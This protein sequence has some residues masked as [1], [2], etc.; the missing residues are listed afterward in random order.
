MKEGIEKRIL[1]WS[2]IPLAMLI[3]G[4]IAPEVRVPIEVL[5]SRGYE[6]LKFIGKEMGRLLYKDNSSLY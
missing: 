4:S 1:E 6:K 5:V 2:S 3:C